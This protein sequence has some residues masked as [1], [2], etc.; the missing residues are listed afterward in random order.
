V[1]VRAKASDLLGDGR[2]VQRD[3]GLVQEGVILRA[4][5]EGAT[6]DEDVVRVQREVG[7][8]EDELALEI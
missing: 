7:A 1:R 5:D 3:G 2:A 8:V 4:H 6:H